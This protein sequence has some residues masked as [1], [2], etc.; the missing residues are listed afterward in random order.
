MPTPTLPTSSTL[1]TASTAAPAAS[2]SSSALT[3]NRRAL[4]LLCLVLSLAS[5]LLLARYAYLEALP[6]P[7]PPPPL[8]PPER[9]GW[10]REAGRWLEEYRL[11]RGGKG[12]AEVE[13]PPQPQ[14]PTNNNPLTHPQPPIA[15]LAL[16]THLLTTPPLYRSSPLLRHQQKHTRLSLLIASTITLAAFMALTPDGATPAARLRAFVLGA[17]PCTLALGAGI[18][19]CV[20]CLRGVGVGGGRRGV[21]VGGGGLGLEENA[22]GKWRW[23]PDGR[24]GAIEEGE[25]ERREV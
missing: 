3:R 8:P 14:P 9:E 25:M 2:S 22:V 4:H 13:V 18:A 11:G 20:G 19:A 6:P 5:A 17:V 21:R 15:L 10:L 12:G 7:P 24:L 16:L 1:S 23:E